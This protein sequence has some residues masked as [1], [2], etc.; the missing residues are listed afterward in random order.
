MM[1]YNTKKFVSGYQSMDMHGIWV[2]VTFDGGLSM[3]ILR[4]ERLFTK[5]NRG[6]N[7][8]VF[9][10]LKFSTLQTPPFGKS[11]SFLVPIFLRTE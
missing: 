1:I 7:Q 2:P 11:P 4:N 6:Q 5:K 8:S 10:K 9:N 3:S